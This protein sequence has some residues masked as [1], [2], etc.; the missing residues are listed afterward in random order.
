VPGRVRLALGIKEDMVL[1][2]ETFGSSRGSFRGLRKTT[3]GLEVS[4]RE[5]GEPGELLTVTIS[6]PT[7]EELRR[8]EREALAE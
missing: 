8:Y 3:S 7:G 4:P 2:F 5:M 1:Y 6:V